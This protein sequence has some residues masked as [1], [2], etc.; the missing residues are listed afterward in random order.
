M[1]SD[2]G[3]TRAAY[4]QAI[5]SRKQRATRDPRRDARAN[6]QRFEVR[7][8]GRVKRC[9][10]LCLAYV[11]HISKTATAAGHMSIMRAP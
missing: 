4:Q 5:S 3:P 9:R 10:P 2:A 8:E 6:V 11:Q 1:A 7:W